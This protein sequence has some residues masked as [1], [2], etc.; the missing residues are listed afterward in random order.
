MSPTPQ[1]RTAGTPQIRKEGMDKV[2]SRARYI[3]DIR[4]TAMYRKHVAANLLDEFLDTL[5]QKQAA[6]P[7]A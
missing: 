3:D 4:S 6:E 2:L 5:E 1:T 7:I